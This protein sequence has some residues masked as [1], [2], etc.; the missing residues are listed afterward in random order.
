MRKNVLITGIGG[1]IAQGI[2]VILR[3]SF[4][5]WQ[6]TG[7]DVHSRHSGSLFVD[8]FNEAPKA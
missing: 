4:P 7:I 1:D 3:Q 8:Q 6:L 2:A 5:D